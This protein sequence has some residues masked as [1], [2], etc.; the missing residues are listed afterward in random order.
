MLTFG[1]LVTTRV[2]YPIRYVQN[3]YISI[4]KMDVDGRGCLD[5]GRGRPNIMDSLTLEK[6]L[7]CPF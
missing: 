1:K 2:Q 5:S 7:R 6:S 4:Y 3:L